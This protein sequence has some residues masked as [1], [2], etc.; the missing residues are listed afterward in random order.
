MFRTLCLR[1][2]D[3]IYMLKGAAENM[4]FTVHVSRI[5]G[6]YTNVSFCDELWA[7]CEDK[8]LCTI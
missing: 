2:Y 4:C 3:V 5:L 7:L 8:T 6:L 1:C